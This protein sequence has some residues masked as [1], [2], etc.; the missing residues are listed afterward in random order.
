MPHTG[1]WGSFEIFSIGVDHLV[2]RFE[3]R[4]KTIGFILIEFVAVE[5]RSRS[6]LRNTSCIRHR[7]A[8]KYHFSTSIYGISASDCKSV[9]YAILMLCCAATH[10]SI[11]S[12][13]FFFCFVHASAFVSPSSLSPFLC[14]TTKHSSHWWKRD[15]L[16]F[17]RSIDPNTMRSN[18]NNN[19]KLHSNKI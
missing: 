5:E 17:V 18:N 3:R 1:E 6:W 11:N 19:K 10:I 7:I 12:S 4:S 13:F 16:P 8:M 15:S 2:N 14:T 9:G